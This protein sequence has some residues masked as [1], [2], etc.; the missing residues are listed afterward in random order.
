MKTLL[1]F[2]GIVDAIAAIL[3]L[4]AGNVDRA[5]LFTIL[6]WLVYIQYTL[7]EKQDGQE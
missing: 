1:I 6:Q 3:N 5:L 4:F 2:I 7:E